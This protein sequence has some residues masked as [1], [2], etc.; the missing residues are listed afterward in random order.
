M[1][2]LSLYIIC[3][4]SVVIC[5]LSTLLA[6]IMVAAIVNSPGYSSGHFEGYGIEFCIVV[7]SIL[8]GAA[9]FVFLKTRRSIVALKSS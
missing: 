1:K 9:F 7:L 3:T 8:D 6:L 4:L 2:I 5:V